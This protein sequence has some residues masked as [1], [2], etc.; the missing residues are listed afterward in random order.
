MI[1]ELMVKYNTIDLHDKYRKGLNENEKNIQSERCNYRFR[2][3]IFI[4]ITSTTNE[5]V[6]R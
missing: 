4:K 6:N 1:M 3:N 5:Q 2:F